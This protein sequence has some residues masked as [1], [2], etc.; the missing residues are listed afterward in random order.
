MFLYQ[1][2][3]G[4]EVAFV[5]ASRAAKAKRLPVV[6]SSDGGDEHMKMFSNPTTKVWREDGKLKGERSG[7]EIACLRE[8][9]TGTRL[10]MFDLMYGTGLRHKEFRRL[11]IKDIEFD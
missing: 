7:N 11:R 8:R 6:F 9:F 3:F 1:K 2:V 4:R 10:L 5:D